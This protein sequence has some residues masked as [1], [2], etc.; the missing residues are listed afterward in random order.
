MEDDEGCGLPK[1][2]R[3]AVNIAAVAYLF[4]ND[5]RIASRMIAE[6]LNIPKTLVFWILKEDF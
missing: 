4:K 3:T 2:T 5:C 6:Y 1:S